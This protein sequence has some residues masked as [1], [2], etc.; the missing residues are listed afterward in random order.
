MTTRAPDL[1]S[2]TSRLSGLI[3]F[4]AAA[5]AAATMSLGVGGLGGAA[6]ISND[7]RNRNQPSTHASLPLAPRSSRE[8]RAP[9]SA[10][11]HV[12]RHL[13]AARLG[14]ARPRIRHRGQAARLPGHR[15][16]PLRQRPRDAG[17][18]RQRSLRHARRQGAQGRGQEAQARRHHP[19]DRGDRHRRAGR[20]RES[21]L[22]RRALGQGGAADHEPRRHPR[23][24][25]AASSAW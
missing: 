20:A 15:L 18:R 4:H 6:P 17:R 19:R 13:D 14:R 23:V 10:L 1:R 25:G 22:P 7:G 8:E 2:M 9:L 24:R 12:H 16:R 5:G 3:A 11:P 21:G